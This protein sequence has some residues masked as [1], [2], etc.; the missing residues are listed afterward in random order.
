MS[1]RIRCLALLTV[2][3]VTVQA[4]DWWEGFAPWG[5]DGRVYTVTVHGGDLYAAGDFWRAGGE[6]CHNVARWDGVRWRPVGGGTNALVNVLLSTETALLM[7]GHF[8]EVDG[9]PALRAA[10]R[11][12]GFWYQLGD[13]F[14]DA[15]QDMIM[16][17]ATLVAGGHFDASGGAVSYTHLTLPTTP[18]V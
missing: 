13:G 15:V 11:E 8:T 16:M 9:V 17:D 18:Y 7:G 4:Q 5:V 6:E 14:D 2:L 3:A 10:K 12:G 1:I